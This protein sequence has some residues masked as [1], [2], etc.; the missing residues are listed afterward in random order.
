M[1]LPPFADP[2]DYAIT[3]GSYTDRTQGDLEA[4]STAI[5][6]YCRWRVWPNES[7]VFVLD[8]PGSPVLTVPSL[9][10][11]AVTS[12]SETARGSGQS[13][14]VVDPADLEWSAAG[15]IRHSSGR[16]W[17]ARARGI[18]L[19]VT[20]GLVDVPEDLRR[21]VLDL[22]HRSAANPAGRSAIQVGQRMEQFRGG[23][24]MGML[25]DELAIAD[26]YRRVV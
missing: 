8:G 23:A 12:L 2:G 1:V 24:P 11:T 21:L 10:L 4:A 20:H 16:C 25:A 15:F 9:N 3:F 5:R 17:T 13:P 26:T 18:S 7:E 6:R 19:T 14:V 22:A